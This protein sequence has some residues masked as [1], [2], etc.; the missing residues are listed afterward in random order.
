MSK[1]IRILIADDHPIVLQGLSSL[2]D[3][4]PDMTVVGVARDGIEAV[5]K[6]SCLLPDV[7]LMD[8]VM[9]RQDGLTAIRQIKEANLPVHILVLTSYEE[10]E[11]ILPAIRSGALGYQI[12]DA[13]PELLLQAIR[14][15]HRGEWALDHRA[16]AKLVAQTTPFAG[17]ASVGDEA[18]SERE[19]EV[20][21]LVAQ[22]LSNA[23]IAQRLSLTEHT[24][25]GHVSR[26]LQK[27]QVENRTQA[28]LYALR[29]GLAGLG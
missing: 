27:L 26:I 22:G 20:L 23:Q 17:T 29:T 9:P 7:I 1:S 19:I 11:H 25:G 15:V 18:L 8:L 24:V 10:N 28:A 16:T 13:E 6:A 12:K 2:L 4:Q 5:E 14:L 3:S 21:K